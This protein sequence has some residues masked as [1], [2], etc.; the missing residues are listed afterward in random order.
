[1][2]G[3]PQALVSAVMAV[4][5]NEKYV[6]SAIGSFMDQGYP[7][8]ELIV[9]DDGSDDRSYE[10]M[11]SLKDEAERRFQRVILACR[12]HLGVSPSMAWGCAQAEGQYLFV[13]GSDDLARPEAVSKLQSFLGS[14]PEYGLAA[15]DAELIGPAGE[16]VR[17]NKNGQM[18]GPGEEGF[19][20]H[21]GFLRSI[22]HGVD[23]GSADFGSY[24]SLLHGNYIPSS[25]LIRKAAYDQVG[26]YDPQFILEDWH[27][28]LKLAKSWKM[29][30]FPD[31]L[32][33]YRR[34]PGCT[35][36]KKPVML[37]ALAQTIDHEIQWVLANGPPEEKSLVKKFLDSRS[38]R[39][40]L[41]SLGC[42]L[43]LS[44][45]KF[46]MGDYYAT[47]DRVLEVFGREVYR[48]SK[49]YLAYHDGLDQ[50]LSRELDPTDLS[51]E[52]N[53]A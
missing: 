18:C 2:N 32:Y 15:G 1:M 10:I 5:N 50:P 23:F 3:A 8:M 27:L 20:R 49:K 36:V 26:G 45:E 24:W 31:I 44:M 13:L 43:R 25:S 41:F 40:T 17:L 7:N 11:Q 39:V 16:P 28:A 34:H 38:S 51:R 29:K 53:L 33:S 46:G 30:F 19:A 37:K 9:V 52:T 21:S 48:R 12:P 42:W 4:W 35:M 47:R 6:A 22:S 14:N